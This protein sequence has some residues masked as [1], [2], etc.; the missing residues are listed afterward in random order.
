MAFQISTFLSKVG[1]ENALSLK[2]YQEKNLL[3]TLKMFRKLKPVF[4]IINRENYMHAN[5]Y[6]IK[7]AKI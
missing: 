1:V 5:C 4:I 2:N 3:V 7:I 6:I